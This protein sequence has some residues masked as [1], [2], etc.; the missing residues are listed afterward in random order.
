MNQAGPASQRTRLKLTVHG[1]VQG[2]GFIAGV[3]CVWQ[4]FRK[5]D[6]IQDGDGSHRLKVAALAAATFLATP[7]AF[8]YDLPLFT[9]SV[10]LFIDERRRANGRFLFREVLAIVAGMMLP[11][12]ILSNGLRSCT[13]IMI[14]IMLCTILSRLRSLQRAQAHDSMKAYSSLPALVRA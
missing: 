1:A 10:L 11:C 8:Y 5:R 4:C 7:F 14:A 13:S 3:I 2:V 12:F 9:C 6:G